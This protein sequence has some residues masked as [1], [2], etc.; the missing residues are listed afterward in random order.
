MPW[1]VGMLPPAPKRGVTLARAR[2]KSGP[3]VSNFWSAIIP[4][5]E[6]AMRRRETPQKT[7]TFDVGC[8]TRQR[9]GTSKSGR[10][11]ACT[12]A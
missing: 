6:A 7:V 10:N 2:G 1:P 4:S 11:P 9:I 12:R 8:R 3:S 5:D